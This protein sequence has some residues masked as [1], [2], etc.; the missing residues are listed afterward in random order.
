MGTAAPSIESSTREERL[1]Y[2]QER[3]PCIAD[4]DMCG[5]CAAYHGKDPQAAYKDYIEGA[6]EFLEVSLRYR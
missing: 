2:V 3:F 4:C 6:A 5:F 1:R